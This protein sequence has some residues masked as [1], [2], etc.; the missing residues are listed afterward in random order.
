[1]EERRGDRSKLA[2][3]KMEIKHSQI[4][5]RV[6]KGFLPNIGEFRNSVQKLNIF[7]ALFAMESNLLLIEDDQKGRELAIQDVYEMGGQLM[8]GLLFLEHYIVYAHLRRLGFKLRIDESIPSSI[9]FLVWK[10]GGTKKDHPPAFKVR[11]F[12]DTVDLESIECGIIYAIVEGSSVT[13]IN[14]CDDSIKL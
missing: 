12:A 5:I 4:S 11:L 2:Q 10:P 13:F 9:L 7:E 14:A 8:N 3:S 1:M 6:T